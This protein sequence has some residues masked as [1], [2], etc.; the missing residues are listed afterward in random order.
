MG[1]ESKRAEEKEEETEREGG[2]WGRKAREQRRRRIFYLNGSPTGLMHSTMW[3]L[4]RTL[5]I[6]YVNIVSGMSAIPSFLA[7]SLK[8]CLT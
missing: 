4:F 5:S 3:R 1:E 2:R 7:G 8:A 6:K